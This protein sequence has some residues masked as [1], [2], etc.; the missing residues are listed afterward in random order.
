[1]LEM[2]SS[3]GV[4]A[5]R[6]CAFGAATST[7]GAFAGSTST[8]TGGVPAPISWR[9]SPNRATKTTHPAAEVVA[10]KARNNTSRLRIGYRLDGSGGVA[11]TA[12]SI[13]PGS[14]IRLTGGTDFGETRLVRPAVRLVLLRD[15]VARRDV[16]RFA[17]CAFVG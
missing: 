2:A 16:V 12:R 4:D 13:S 14:S 15:V 11:A 8:M 5:M 17:T 10:A 1:M 3:L 6:S 7:L 9:A